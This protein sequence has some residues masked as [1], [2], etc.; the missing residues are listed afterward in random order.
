MKTY[1]GAVVKF[2]D[3]YG[4]P[5]LQVF[6][7]KW[8]FYSYSVASKEAIEYIGRRCYFKEA[9]VQTQ[10]QASQAARA[11]QPQQLL[12]HDHQMR[13]QIEQ[14]MSFTM[15]NRTNSMHVDSLLDWLEREIE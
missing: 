9:K 8:L 10:I 13:Q 12:L 11:Q 2:D 5:R 15:T 4:T 1:P 7:G 6:I 14:C 3:A